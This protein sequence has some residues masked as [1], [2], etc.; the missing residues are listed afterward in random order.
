MKEKI[1]D[2]YIYP[3][4]FEYEV[5]QEIAVLFSD[6]DT[7][8]SGINEEDALGS[9]RELLGLIL[10]GLEEDG[11]FIPVPSKPEDLSLKNNQKIVLIDVNMTRV[12]KE[13][14]ELNV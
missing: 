2:Q 4:I 10:Y 14:I 5:G 8:T 6:L 11:E 3:A 12:R 1:K 13:V 9:A 7:A